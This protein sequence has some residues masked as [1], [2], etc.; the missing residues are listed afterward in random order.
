M[1]KLFNPDSKLSILLNRV[2][3]FVVLGVLWMVCCLPVFTIGAATTALYYASLKLLAGEESYLAKDFFHSF[4]MN[5]KQ[6]T[7]LWL[8]AIA[9]GLFLAYDMML[10]HRLGYTVAMVAVAGLAFICVLTLLYLFPYLSKF[11]CTFT[12]AIKAALFMSFRHFGRSILLL[13]ADALLVATAMVN[14]FSA[15]LLPAVFVYINSLVFRQ[16]FKKYLPEPPKETVLS[17]EE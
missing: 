8:T 3:D 6:A 2:A 9:V 16:I 1:G 7:L 13:A 10:C 11:Y 14:P 17:G 5:F 15:V 12:Q 4:K